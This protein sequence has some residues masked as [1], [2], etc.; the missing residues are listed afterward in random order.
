MRQQDQLDRHSDRIEPPSPGA[1]ENIDET[2][3]YMCQAPQEGAGTKRPRSPL[4]PNAETHRDI[5]DSRNTAQSDNFNTRKMRTR[6]M[7]A[8]LLSDPELPFPHLAKTALEAFDSA[9]GKDNTRQTYQATL[10][11]TDQHLPHNT[12]V[13][14]ATL[15][16][17]GEYLIDKITRTGIAPHRE[18]IAG[19]PGTDS[20]SQP[21]PNRA[22]LNRDNATHEGPHGSGQRSNTTPPPSTW[23]T[24]TARHR[25]APQTAKPKAAK[26][27]GTPTTASHP[28]HARKA[29]A[30]KVVV[31]LFSPIITDRLDSFT[32]RER[33]NSSLRASSAAAHVAISSITL[34]RSGNLCLR[35]KEGCTADEIAQY[36]N[37]WEP[38]IPLS[39]SGDYNI[40]DVFVDERWHK[41]LLGHVPL[42]IAGEP[43]TMERLQADI[44]GFNAG[45]SLQQAP[46]WLVGEERRGDKQH[47]SV[48]LSFKDEDAARRVLKRGL[49]VFGRPAETHLRRYYDTRPDTQCKRCQGYSHL[50]EMCR[51]KPACAICAE[52]HETTDHWCDKC[53]S[54]GKCHH[55]VI[56]CANCCEGHES[57]FNLCPKRKALQ[58]RSSQWEATQ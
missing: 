34:S 44:E 28:P 21:A 19:A 58:A 33:I 3:K 15:H 22:S 49:E 24:V 9:I 56:R 20:V 7:L 38:V 13:T 26:P 40:K 35:A 41:L 6:A 25:P 55:A 39:D 53:Q 54:L 52:P 14:M 23:A 12:P 32:L 42:Q 47:S 30:W 16:E 45:V 1:P 37:A 18:A 4:S 17:F 11:P 29:D 51:A 48:V 43:V 2:D 31:A 57:T 46:R 5:P 36:R 50:R 8:N 27:K 10:S